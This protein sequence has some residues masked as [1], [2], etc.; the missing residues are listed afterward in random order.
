MCAQAVLET[1]LPG[2]RL[3]VW[4]DPIDL[5]Y[6]CLFLDEVFADLLAT[7]ATFELQTP[8]S[9]IRGRCDAE[10]SALE[11]SDL[12]LAFPEA[13]R[14]QYQ[15]EV[16]DS[17]PLRLRVLF[18]PL[19][20]DPAPSSPAAA[21]SVSPHRREAAPPNA[22]EILS[23]AAR[24]CFA[25]IEAYR[26]GRAAWQLSLS[27]GFDRLL[28]LPMLRDMEVMEHQVKAAQTVLRRHRACALLCDEVGLGKTIEA[29]MVLAELTAR[30]IARRVLILTPPSLLEQW[31]GEL[32]RKFSLDFVTQDHPAFREAGTKAWTQFD[33]VVAS[34]HTAKREPHRG[35]ILRQEYDLVIVDEAHHL[36][37]RNTVLWKFAAGLRKRFM[38]LLTATPVQN[39]LEDVFNLITLLK[40]GYLSTAQS[41]R[42]QFVARAGIVPKNLDRLQSILAEVMVRNRRSQVGVRFTRRFARTLE[43]PLPPAEAAFYAELSSLVR[44]SVRE[45]ASP[46][47]MAL[48]TLQAEAGSSPAATRETLL[49]LGSRSE[50]TP[51]LRGRFG[52]LADQA[53]RLGPGAKSEAFLRLLQG[54]PE[55]L[56]VFTRFRATLN[57]LARLLR[58]AGIPTAVFHGGLPRRDRQQA[59][60]SF[61]GESRILLSSDAGSEGRNLQF[62]HAVCN[63][64]LPWNP[65]VL[66]Q[67]IGR[68]SRIGQR[69]DVEV[70]NLVAAGTLKSH[71][72]RLLDVKLRMFELVV[73]EIDMVL[74]NLENDEEFEERVLKLWVDSPDEQ[75]FSSRLDRLGEELLRAKEE[76]LRARRYDDAL[77]GDRYVPEG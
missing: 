57:L 73:G 39:K 58:E 34:F 36:R 46:G 14:A 52:G 37:N 48:R 69:H 27:A 40:P 59:I 30:R 77:F 70:F 53:E 62:C 24:A 17:Y 41:F 74:G 42:K 28:C 63:Y 29:G 66:E 35:E 15:L 50:L 43:V 21:S 49:S 61:E 2:D 65:M 11:A 12:A 32:E 54:T 3:Q 31:H 25:P 20:A 67:R 10:S 4:P 75:A 23:L 47:R 18:S 64:D 44:Q 60:R 5:R 9:L 72:L 55:K 1:L 38:L 22:T 68:L 45:D 8:T 6:G 76:Y 51:E 13:G 71:V 56:V 33:R 7:A 16:V 26:L 19:D